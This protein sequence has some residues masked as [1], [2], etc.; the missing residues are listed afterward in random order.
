ML[1]FFRNKKTEK[2]QRNEDLP[3]SNEEFPDSDKPYGLCPRCNKQ[4]SFD[5]LG[6]LPA[7]FDSGIIVHQNGTNSR[8]F[9][10]RVTSFQCRNCQQPVIVLEEQ[11]IN[12]KP[13]REGMTGGT[14]NWRGFFWWPFFSLKMNEVI[15]IEIQEILKEAKITYSTECYRSSAVMSRRTLEA[16]AT[17]KGENKGVLAKRIQNLI[18]KGILDKNLG[19]W[20]T[21][22]RLIGNS[23]AHYDPINEVNKA[24]ANQ[25]ILFIEELIK[26]LYIMPS[27]IEKRRQ[28]K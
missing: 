16:I 9:Y 13:R 15:P 20:A 3:E 6:S 11:F 5:I 10:D 17:D 21:E 24:D 7:T 2:G 25:I 8:D 28:K 23:G 22:I 4:S 27:E 18:D 14:I 26:Y 1:N 19:E 12:D